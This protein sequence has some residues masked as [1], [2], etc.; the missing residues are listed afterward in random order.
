MMVSWEYLGRQTEL[1]SIHRVRVK[2]KTSG[3]CE[4]TGLAGRN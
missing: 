4:R 3:K 1:L 2:C